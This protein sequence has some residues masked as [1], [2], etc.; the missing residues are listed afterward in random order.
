MPL[1]I[2]LSSNELSTVIEVFNALESPTFPVAI[3]QPLH[4]E[5]LK[6]IAYLSGCISPEVGGDQ[7]KVTLSTSVVTLRFSGAPIVCE[8]KGRS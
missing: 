4:P 1:G 5:Q 7:F 3:P 2:R 8:T 6:N